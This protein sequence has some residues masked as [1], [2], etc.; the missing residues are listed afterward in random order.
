MT[1][2]CDMLATNN[3]RWNTLFDVMTEQIGPVRLFCGQRS[4]LSQFAEGFIGPSEG[5]KSPQLRL[6]TQYN[7]DRMASP[8]RFG[9]ANPSFSDWLGSLM[10]EA[11]KALW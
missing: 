4:T 2:Q 9:S 1:Y 5:C 6:I 10:G 7:K 8:G 3:Y 11:L